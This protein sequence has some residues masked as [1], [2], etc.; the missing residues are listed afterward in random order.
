[1]DQLFRG[2]R[3]MST[4]VQHNTGTKIHLVHFRMD[5]KEILRPIEDHQKGA[6]END[7]GE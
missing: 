6:H 7:S 3:H 4:A 5:E 1:M 2:R